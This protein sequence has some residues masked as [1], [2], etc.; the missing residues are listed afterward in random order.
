MTTLHKVKPGTAVP[1]QD[2]MLQ[3]PR[4]TTTVNR[5]DLEQQMIDC[6]QITDDIKAMHDMGAGP[7]DIRTLATLYEY[8]F[9]RMWATFEVMVK[10]GQ[11]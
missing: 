9:K 6:W 3:A 4:P 8:K 11:V 7:D 5:F 2:V 1:Y 10:E